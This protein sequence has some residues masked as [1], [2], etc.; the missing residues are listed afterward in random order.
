ML[1]INP[2]PLSYCLTYMT[3]SKVWRLRFAK[4]SE[5]FLCQKSLVYGRV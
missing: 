5:N 1:I 3:K 2:K 4:E